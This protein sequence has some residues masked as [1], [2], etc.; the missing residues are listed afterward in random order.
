MNRERTEG[1]TAHCMLHASSHQP[2]P[3]GIEG[4]CRILKNVNYSMALV[5]V[6]FVGAAVAPSLM[7]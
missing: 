6:C 7:K 1:G 5:A 2:I 4:F 3:V